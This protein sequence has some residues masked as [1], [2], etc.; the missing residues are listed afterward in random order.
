M[1]AASDLGMHFLL[2]SH[3]KDARHIYF[4]SSDKKKNSSQD[5][6]ATSFEKDDKL[7]CDQDHAQTGV[8]THLCRTY[9]P[10]LINWTRPFP[11]Q[12]FWMVFFIFIQFLIKY[13]V[14]KQ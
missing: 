4:K 9:F 5:G 8:L 12:G 13:S 2:M 7:T 1:N 11:L 3:K 10:I 6:V 14:S